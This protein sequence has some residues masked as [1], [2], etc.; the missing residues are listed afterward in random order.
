MK[1]EKVW[2]LCYSATGTTDKLT[3]AVAEAA[4]K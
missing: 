3:S 4:A 1:I 2:A